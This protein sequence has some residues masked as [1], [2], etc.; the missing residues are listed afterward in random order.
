MSRL[1]IKFLAKQTDGSYVPSVSVD[2]PMPSNAAA[3][4]AATAM[5]FWTAP[6]SD[7]HAATI[8][9]LDDDGVP[10]VLSQEA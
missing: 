7:I 4:A 5:R 8:L 2:F 6:G 10:I 1:S 9:P 3:V